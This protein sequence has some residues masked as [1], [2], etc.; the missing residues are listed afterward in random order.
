MTGKRFAYNMVIL[1]GLAF[2]TLMV[3]DLITY[4][5]MKWMAR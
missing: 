1:F 5:L 4:S 3:F 2:M